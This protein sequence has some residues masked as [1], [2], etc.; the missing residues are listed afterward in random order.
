[1]GDLDSVFVQRSTG[2]TQTFKEEFADTWVEY[3]AGVTAAFDN[4]QFF[5]E[6]SKSLSADL[7]QNW[8]FNVGVRYS[9]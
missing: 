7:E 3:G 1:M 5:A 6:T 4:L 8:R 2:N 9:F